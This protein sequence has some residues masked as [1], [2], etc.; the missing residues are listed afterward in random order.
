[1]VKHSWGKA[2]IGMIATLGAAALAIAGLHRF[3]GRAY[4]ADPAPALFVTDNC[5][6]GVMAFPAE[7]YGDI[8]P[9]APAPTG[10]SKPQFVAIDKNSN[11]YATNLCTRTITIYA[12]GSKGI[13]APTAIIGG[14]STGLSSPEG[15]AVDSDSNIYVADFNADSVFVYSAGSS[16]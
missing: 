2:R 8:S 5:S 9:L 3:S 6:Q 14:T 15:I 16:G 13:A 1:M 4:S 7:T 12:E 11:I 10:L